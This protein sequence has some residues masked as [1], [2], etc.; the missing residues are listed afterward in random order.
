MS[1]PTYLLAQGSSICFACERGFFSDQTATESCTPCPRGTYQNEDGATTCVGCVCPEVQ[2]L[3][4]QIAC[5]ACQSGKCKSVLWVVCVVCE[6]SDVTGVCSLGVCEHLGAQS[7]SLVSW[8]P[9]PHRSHSFPFALSRC[10][11]T[12]RLGACAATATCRSPPMS[13]L[14]EMPKARWSPLR[15]ILKVVRAILSSLARI[16]PHATSMFGAGQCIDEHHC[17]QNRQ[18]P[19]QKNQLCGNSFVAAHLP[20]DRADCGRPMSSWIQRMVSSGRRALSDAA[21]TPN[22]RSAVQGRPL[23]GM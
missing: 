5:D 17:G 12:V 8:R 6:S 3:E 22:C 21:R 15:A 7:K 18:Q 9:E 2:P 14:R 11:W 16:D 1:A 20:R 4:A 19:P 10:A 13:T 23:P